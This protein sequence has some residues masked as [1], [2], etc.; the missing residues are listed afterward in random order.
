MDIKKI[1]SVFAGIFAVLLLVVL[2]VMA[3]AKEFMA[4]I[5]EIRISW[6]G[7]A[8][9]CFFLGNILRVRQ[10]QSSIPSL[11]NVSWPCLFAVITIH[12]FAN[13]VLPAR[14]GELTYV[15]LVKKYL[16]QRLSIGFSS[17]IIVRILELVTLLMIII[18]AGMIMALRKVSFMGN[19]QWLLMGSL[20]SLSI[21]TLFYLPALIKAGENILK[22]LSRKI[23]SGFVSRQINK[24]RELFL[25][26]HSELHQRG[27]TT[28]LFST[29]MYS[30]MIWITLFLM[31]AA[32]L[33]SLGVNVGIDMIIIGSIGAIAANAL[34]IN[35][36][37][38]IGTL[39]AGWTAG[40]VAVGVDFKTALTAGIVMH[41]LVIIAGGILSLLAWIYLNL[42]R[43]GK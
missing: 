39:E 20:L 22:N 7:S 28:P 19:Y 21:M 36:I 9:L 26:I 18:T 16:G 40:F 10:F 43:G 13:H 32:V 42:L 34:P 12:K 23:S 27:S 8:L 2:V 3:D 6:I 5:K 11:R 24:L 4:S 1:S 31:F 35:A 41:A 17:L 25:E 33:R 30:L 38:S 15:Y 14:S 37:G 29:A